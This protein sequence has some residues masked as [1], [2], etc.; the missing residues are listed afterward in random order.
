MPSANT[1]ILFNQAE[2]RRVWDD[3]KELWYFSIIDIIS[4]LSES[5]IPKR[6]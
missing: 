5:T 2:V 4:I 1:I 3:T 6:Y